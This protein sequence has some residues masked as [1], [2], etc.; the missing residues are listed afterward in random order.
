MILLT[1]SRGFIGSRIKRILDENDHSVR[2]ILR[3]IQGESD[4]QIGDPLLPKEYP[5]R[6]FTRQITSTMK[7]DVFR[8]DLCDADACR[9]AM[10]DVRIV[11]HAAGEKRDHSRFRPVNVQGT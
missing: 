7:G 9:K 4:Y 2:S 1:G 10:K 11:I 3:N 5:V 8:G 6:L